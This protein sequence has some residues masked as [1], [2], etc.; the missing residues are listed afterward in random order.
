MRKG[1]AQFLTTWA[2]ASDVRTREIA[3][4]RRRTDFAV[5]GAVI[6]LRDPGLSREIQLLECEVLLALQHREQPTIDALLSNIYMRRFI[7]GWTHLGHEQRLGA[8]IVSCADDLVI[9]CKGGAEETLLAMQN[10]MKRLKLTVNER[11]TH[12]CVY[13]NSTSTFWVIHSAGFIRRRDEPI[14]ALVHQRK[15]C[16][17]CYTA[18]TSR[19]LA[20]AGKLPVRFDERDVETELWFIN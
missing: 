10:I 13:R 16:N 11:K 2:L 8:H 9:C 1:G 17:G 12:V 20:D 3:L 19:P 7:L 14:W 5:L 15:V 4:H 6:F 18:S